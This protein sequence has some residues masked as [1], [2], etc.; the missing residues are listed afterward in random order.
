MNVE[1]KRSCAISIILLIVYSLFANTSAGS[2]LS[3]FRQ[4]SDFLMLKSFEMDPILA[5]SA[6]YDNF[7][8]KM[9]NLSKSAIASYDS[10]INV[11]YNMLKNMDTTGWEIEDQ[12]DYILEMQNIEVYLPGFAKEEELETSAA[13]YS[14]SC[15]FG[16]ILITSR[17]NN[18]ID[19]VYRCFI[20]R[21]N[22]IPGFL[23]S[24]KG[25]IKEFNQVDL[26]YS[27]QYLMGAAEIIKGYCDNLVDSLPAENGRISTARDKAVLAIR[28]FVDFLSEYGPS[29]P[30]YH[31]I[32]KEEFDR[33]LKSDYFI[34]INSDSLMNLAD[35]EFW[36]ADSLVK[37]Q[38]LKLPTKEEQRFT[39][40][41][42]VAFS[43]SDEEITTYC[44]KEI[45]V[46]SHFLNDRKILTVSDSLPD[47]KFEEMP[48]YL[49]HAGYSSDLFIDDGQLCD[50]PRGVYY[51]TFSSLSYSSYDDSDRDSIEYDL[52]QNFAE[53]LIP[54]RYF[55]NEILRNENS[56]I[57]KLYINAVNY[58]GWF[59][60]IQK[61]LIEQGLFGNDPEVLYKYY[62]DL[63]GYALG[64]YINI[65]YH[66]GRFSM[67]SL[68]TIVRDRI[69]TDSSAY[70]I[71]KGINSFMPFY[72]IGKFYG[73]LLFEQM[74]QNAQRKEGA[75]FK[76]IEFHDKVLSEGAIPLALIQR[77]YDW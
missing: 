15:F 5:T 1:I 34:D 68:S 47:I 18:N 8:D 22:E 13:F 17:Q 65:G 50:N 6:G 19:E 54:G 30:Q 61:L 4:R 66:T 70:E 37:F 16:I 51:S 62:C 27:I 59:V 56:K 49:N 74:R 26:I 21:L 46:I 7:N 20:G 2:D 77:K 67:D 53:N 23:D 57:R 69:G 10:L 43:P 35:N 76:I 38:A 33:R 73:R 41:G 64:M 45:K 29:G 42:G 14:E 24:A 52:R 11:E 12:L 63:R 60:Y 58:E 25:I 31:P 3:D 32:G 71:N 40:C 9:P 48:S 75:N 28:G 36:R 55:Q 44:Q 39:G 72:Y